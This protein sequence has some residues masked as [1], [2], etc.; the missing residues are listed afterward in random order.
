AMPYALRVT[1]GEAQLQVPKGRPAGH[2]G[3]DRD[4][5]AGLEGAVEAEENAHVF[6]VDVDIDEAPDL[7]VIL[8]DARLEAGVGSFEAVD[9]G[10]K[11]LAL[12]GDDVEVIGDGAQGRRD[13]NLY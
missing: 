6:A 3:D 9:R 5:V 2:R 11:C 7:A 8:A 4:L 10:L 13:A 1:A 12:A